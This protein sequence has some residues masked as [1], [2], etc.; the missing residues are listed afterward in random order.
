M[1]NELKK[2]LVALLKKLG[3]N[4]GD[5]GQYK[6]EF[7]W[8]IVRTSGYNRAE[9]Y[10]LSLRTISLT[11]DI[12]SNYKGEREILEI[13]ENIGNNI[14]EMRNNNPAILNIIQHQCRIIGDKST[15]PVRKH[16][17]ISYT[18]NMATGTKEDYDNE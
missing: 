11:I 14:A 7:P 16:G 18:F 4:V 17:I 2:Q 12:F 1:V 8:L 9:T 15:G 6:E 3:Y 10:D 13:I 5:G